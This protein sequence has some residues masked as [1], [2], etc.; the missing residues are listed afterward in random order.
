MAD[1]KRRDL[2][3]GAVGALATAGA[4]MLAR[5][6]LPR[7]ETEIP[8]PP[9]GGPTGTER[10]SAVP[11]PEGLQPRP[12]PDDATRVPGP[13]ASEIGQRSP[14]ETPRRANFDVSSGTPHQELMGTVTPS[15]LHFERHHGG[16]AMIDPAHYTLLIHGMVDRPLVLTLDELKSFPSVS[17]T[18]F[19][20]CSG[21]MRRNMP[22]AT[23]PR[24]FCGLTSQSEW[25]GVLLSTL[26]REVGV[27]PDAGWLLA[28]GGDA[29]VMARSV[30]LEKALDD[31]IV[32][33][34]QNGEAIRPENGYPVR[35][36]CPGWEGSVNVKWLRRIKVGDEPFMTRWET[37]RYTVAHRDGRAR[38]FNFVM[39]PRSIITRPSYPH[40]IEP[41][42]VEVQG[43]A[44]SG[45]GRVS[46]AELSFDEGTSWVEA[47]LQSPALPK[48]HTRFR[49][50]WRWDGQETTILSRTVDEAGHVQ[51]TQR[52]IIE[53]R[54]AGSG[55][56]HLNPI[57]GWTI[58]PE[59]AVVFRQ[60]EWA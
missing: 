53:A 30:P 33:Y 31:A 42:W 59:G 11:A 29:A 39:G 49:Y 10:P 57:T 46:R 22:E 40:R 19:L 60:E 1:I 35:L 50:L 41:G 3:A 26:L 32:A 15:D 5:I 2:L 43:L 12:V 25:T 8:E 37:G 27:H 16:V 58:R 20:E 45:H 51:P 18:C 28:E 36:V 34:G 44:W 54:G 56:Y 38:K 14:F 52:E 4:W 21:N 17:R 6:P 9:L 13:P 48:A 55:P 7:R 47:D 24:D 23:R